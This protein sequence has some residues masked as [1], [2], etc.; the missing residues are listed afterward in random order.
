MITA[1]REQGG[2]EEGWT[3]KQYYKKKHIIQAI[4][5]FKRWRG[6]D[7]CDTKESD[8]CEAKESVVQDFMIQKWWLWGNGQEDEEEDKKNPFFKRAPLKNVIYENKKRSSFK[9]EWEDDKYVIYFK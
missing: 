4:Y 7:D 6:S 1:T 2:Q 3:N 9:G 5:F 8:D